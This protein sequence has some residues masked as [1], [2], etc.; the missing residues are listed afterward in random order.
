MLSGFMR[1]ICPDSS[2]VE[3]LHGKQAAVGS[4][5]ILGNEKNI[6]KSVRFERRKEGWQKKRFKEKKHI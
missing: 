6:I 3:H 4:S 1:F 2:G 5:P